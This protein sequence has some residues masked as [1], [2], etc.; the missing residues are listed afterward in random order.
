MKYLLLI[1][2]IGLLLLIF[3]GLPDKILYSHDIIRW[4]PFLLIFV[5]QTY[6]LYQLLKSFN[7]TPKYLLAICAIS[8]L[9]IGPS[10]G[11]YLGYK[12]EK[13]FQEKGHS[14][15]GVVYKKWYAVG[16][17]SEWLLRCE[18]VVNGVRYSTFSETD[19]DNEYQIGDTLTII[20]FEDYPQKSKIKELE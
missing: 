17:N 20:Y 1:L 2:Y 7:V 3:F 16:K 19:E 12:D 5:V 13:D 10:F 4:T 11:F 18:Y 6:L 15:K 14:V 8:V 9:V